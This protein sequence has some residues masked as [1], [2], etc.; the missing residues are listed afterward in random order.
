MTAVEATSLSAKPQRR[1]RLGVMVAAGWRALVEAST[2]E[3]E[4]GRMVA[5]GWCF[6]WLPMSAAGQGVRSHSGRKPE[7]EERTMRKSLR[8]DAKQPEKEVDRR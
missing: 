7:T 4:A 2:S 6:P 3:T 1:G 5:I 8:V